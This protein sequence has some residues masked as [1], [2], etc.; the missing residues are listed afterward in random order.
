MWLVGFLRRIPG[1]VVGQTEKVK[2]IDAI[3]FLRENK[4]KK[5]FTEKV[6]QEIKISEF[7]PGRTTV[8]GLKVDQGVPC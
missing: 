6:R 2:G 4:Q 3:T 7:L 1:Q 8:T 5:L